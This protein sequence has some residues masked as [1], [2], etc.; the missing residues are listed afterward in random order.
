V[1]FS[2]DIGLD[3]ATLSRIENDRQQPSESIDKLIRLLYA[4]SSDDPELIDQVKAILD[5]LL[6]AWKLGPSDVKIVKKIDNNEW[7]DVRLAA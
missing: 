5:S 4:V 2:K 3:A 6:A 1:D 7:S